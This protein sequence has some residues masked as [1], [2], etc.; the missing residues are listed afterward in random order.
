MKPI[1]IV[2]LIVW[3][4]TQ[5][6]KFLYR[7]WLDKKWL[8]HNLTDYGGM[9]SAHSAIAASLAMTILLKEG[10]NSTAFAIAAVYASFI[11]HDALRLR[12]EVEKHAKLLNHLRFKA[13][14]K[15]WHQYPH[16]SERIGH[17]PLEVIMGVVLGILGALILYPLL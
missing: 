5:G 15:E 13:G 16:L 2:P 7:T 6:G 4:L 11:V 9:P 12:M 17:K 14:D 1:L 10:L 3:I 8:L